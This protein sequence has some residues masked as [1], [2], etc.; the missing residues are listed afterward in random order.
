MQGTVT[1]TLP[2]TDRRVR[3]YL[4]MYKGQ[5]IRKVRHI[6]NQKNRISFTTIEVVVPGSERFHDREVMQDFNKVMTLG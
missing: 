5:R 3:K 1:R 2:P 6:H 4:E